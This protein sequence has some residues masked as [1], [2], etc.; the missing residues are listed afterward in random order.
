M[1][2]PEFDIAIVGGGV[3]GTTFACALKDSG[4]RIALIEAELTSQAVSRAQ[5][6]SISLLSSRIFE[7]MGIWQ[8]IRSQV[9]TYKRVQLTDANS[10]NAVKFAPNDIGTE[11]LGY[12]AEHRVLI[13]A[14]HQ[15]LKSCSNVEL[16]CPAKVVK[17]EFQANGATL[18]VMLNGEIQQI[19]SHLVIA[20]DGSRSPLR[21]QAGIKT[22]GWQYGQACVVATLKLESPHDNTAYEW[23]WSTGPSGILPLTDDRYRIVW[24]T[25]R[26]EAEKLV[27]LDDRQFIETFQQRYGSKFGT[28]QIEGNR[29]LFPIQLMHS[30]RYV[31][32]QLAL[33]GDAAHSCHPLGGQGINMGIRDAAA[34]AQVLQTAQKRGED[35]AS[36]KV[37]RRYE[38]WRQW[39]NLIIL[40]ITDILNRTFSN[41][42]FPIVQLRR[43]S[44]WF[45]QNIP[46]IRSLVFRIMSGLTGRAPQLAQR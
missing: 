4:F 12:V 17:T 28:P 24:T 8:E 11:T 44:L 42:I 41:Q 45:L 13:S 16:L 23:F 26:A 40:S 2:L 37:L 43:F 14:L 20:A 21:Q 9:E 1:Q 38:R 19:R 22:F 35:I 6:Y 27:A 29:Y 10:P 36:L 34:L 18:D 32:P 46:P 7:G 3:V 5:A 31:L 25:N 15:L 39:E 33:I 30:R